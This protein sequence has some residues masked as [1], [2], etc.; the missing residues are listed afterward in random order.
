MEEINRS[1]EQVLRRVLDEIAFQTDILALH[2]AVLMCAGENP[3]AGQEFEEETLVLRAI[4]DRL[5]QR[6]D[7][8]RGRSSGILVRSQRSPDGRRTETAAT[9]YLDEAELE[10]DR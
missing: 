5:R 8:S 9:T 6:M 3:A 1:R 4:I 10:S 2:Q 7:R